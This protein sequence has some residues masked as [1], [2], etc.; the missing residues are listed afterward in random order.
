[1]CFRQTEESMRADLS[2]LEDIV[3]ALS[4]TG[5]FTVGDVVDG[6]HKTG[7]RDT[8]IAFAGTVARE[9]NAEGRVRTARA[10][11]SAARSIVKFNHGQD[12]PLCEITAFRLR[13][14]ERWLLDTGLHMNTVSF[15]MRNLRA[16]YNRAV[17]SEIIVPAETNPFGNVYTGVYDTRRRS[18]DRQDINAL[19]GLEKKLPPGDTE[20][21]NALLY[22]LFAYHSRG[23]SF[24]DL[25]YLK[26]SDIKDGSIIYKRKKTGFYIEVKITRPMKRIID[27][28][29]AA[30]KGSPFLFP[31]ID[32][33]ASDYRLRYESALNR[34]NRY[35]KVLAGLA[36]IEKN[37]STHVARHT[38]AT[39]AKRM[40]YNI[41]LISEGLG[42]RDTKVTSIYLA[43]FERSALDELSTRMSRA[44]RAA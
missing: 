33:A 18:L 20:L 40:G 19:A 29:K 13:E 32:P 43:S 22:F 17:A 37:I 21:R 26:K 28:F 14:Y 11:R 16:L 9:L 42:H 27:R 36:G 7:N 30:T 41:S 15:Y 12:M 38:W 24:I 10:Y 3:K 23:M 44:V 2:R 4:K 35:L 31:I 8:V 5:N 1:M 6:F 34:Q 39:L 25:A